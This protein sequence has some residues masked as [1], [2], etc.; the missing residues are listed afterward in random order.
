MT[1]NKQWELQ[2]KL[3]IEKG[4]VD[5]DTDKQICEWV[6]FHQSEDFIMDDTRRN[7]R[8]KVQDGEDVVIDLTRDYD[9]V[10]CATICKGNKYGLSEHNLW[11]LTNNVT[12]SWA[13]EFPIKYTQDNLERT[14]FSFRAIGSANKGCRS[15]MVG[16][17]FY[18]WTEEKYYLVVGVGF[19]KLKLLPDSFIKWK[20]DVDEEFNKLGSI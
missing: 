4:I 13:E 15:S 10:A 11:R 9:M 3:K 1:K 5:L 17:I 7:H 12:E 18:N 6:V 16:D 14:G 20:D 19:N 2:I 8:F